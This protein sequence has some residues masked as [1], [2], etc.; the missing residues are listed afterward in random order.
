MEKGDILSG[1]LLD[2]MPAIAGFIGCKERRGYYLAENQLIPVFKVGDK[3]AARK[4]SLSR[5][6]TALESAADHGEAA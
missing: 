1:D 5:H 4:S 6:F 2:G 3:W